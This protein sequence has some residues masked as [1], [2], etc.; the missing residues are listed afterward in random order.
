MGKVIQTLTAAA[1]Y[2][3]FAAVCLAQEFPGNDSPGALGRHQQEIREYH[4]F[5]QLVKEL[6]KEQKDQAPLVND[7]EVRVKESAEPDAWQIVPE[8]NPPLTCPKK[9]ESQKE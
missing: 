8:K 3:S 9:K 6:E 7:E 1:F 5:R 4:K 2:L